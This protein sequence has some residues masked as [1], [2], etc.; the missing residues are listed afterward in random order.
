MSN[1]AISRDTLHTI[2][3]QQTPKTGRDPQRQT[4]LRARN[5]ADKRDD[6]FAQIE[7][8]VTSIYPGSVRSAGSSVELSRDAAFELAATLLGVRVFTLRDRMAAEEAR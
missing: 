1:A 2:V 8:E 5:V 3:T 7:V 6:H 4:T